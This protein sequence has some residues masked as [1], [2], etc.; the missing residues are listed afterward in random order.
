MLVFLDK[1]F[2]LLAFWEGGVISIIFLKTTK[3]DETYFFSFSRYQFLCL[4]MFVRVRM[5]HQKS[6]AR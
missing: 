1:V 3:L 4:M 6:G 2:C 5:Y